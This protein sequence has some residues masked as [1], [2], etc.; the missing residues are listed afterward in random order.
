MD[1]FQMQIDRWDGAV[2]NTNQ[3]CTT[4]GSKYLH[5][6]GMHVLT[7]G[8]TTSYAFNKGRVSALSVLEAGYFPG[9]FLVIGEEDAMQ[10]DI[11]EV[12]LLFF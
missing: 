10:S 4:L 3:T 6:L 9:L 12:G 2:L 8:D 7:G 5:L 11:L 1:K